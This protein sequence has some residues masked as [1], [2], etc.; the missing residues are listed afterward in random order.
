[1]ISLKV[2][3]YSGYIAKRDKDAMVEE[4]SGADPVCAISFI[5]FS[6]SGHCSFA[7]FCFNDSEDDHIFVLICRWTLVSGLIWVVSKRK[8]QL[9]KI[10]SR[11]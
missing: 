10:L 9:D 4:T 2:L 7:R 11:L 8:N 6:I 3:D 1:M 5:F